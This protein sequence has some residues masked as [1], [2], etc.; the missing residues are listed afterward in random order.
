MWLHV[1][2]V[3]G[4]ALHYLL[5]GGMGDAG[6]AAGPQ[7]D[8]GL[9]SELIPLRQTYQVGSFSKRKTFWA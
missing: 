1:L 9:A 6:L 8:P 2:H 4:Q 7:L 3:A 5:G